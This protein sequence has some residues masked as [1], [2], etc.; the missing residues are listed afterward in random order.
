MTIDEAYAVI[1][2]NPLDGTT[3]FGPFDS[4]NDAHNWAENIPEYWVT[5]LE[6]PDE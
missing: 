2:G 4:Y 1:V 5:R 3:I 6:N